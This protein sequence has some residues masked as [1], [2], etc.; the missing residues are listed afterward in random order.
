MTDGTHDPNLDA[1]R[2]VAELRHHQEELHQQNE[3]LLHARASAERALAE[4][5]D[6][7]DFAPVGYATVDADG[8]VVAANLSLAALFGLGRE[9]IVGR[10]IASWIAPTDRTRLLD[11]LGALKET[12]PPSTLEAGLFNASGDYR[13]VALTAARVAGTTT[14]RIAFSDQTRRHEAERAFQ[15]SQKMEAIG[16][17]AS[18]VAHDLNN[19]FTVVMIHG[20]FCLQELP[21]GSPARADI[22]AMMT[23]IER[24]GA[25]TTRLLSFA[26]PQVMERRRLDASTAV[27]DFAR[28][29]RATTPARVVIACDAPPH[30]G[31]IQFDPAQLEQLL[32]NLANN[33]VD[34]MPD[35][36]TLTLAVQPATLDDAAVAGE[37]TSPGEFIRVRVEDTGVGMR[38][39]VLAHA[40]EPFF[41]TK[42][43]GKGIGLGLATVYAIVHG[44]GGVVRIRSVEGRGTTVDIYLPRSERRPTPTS[45]PTA[46]ATTGGR[47]TILIVEDEPLIRRLT[48]RVLS[49]QGY[50]VHTAEDGVQ[51]LERMAVLGDAVD[52][53]LSDVLMPRMAGPEFVRRVR[54]QR[55]EMPVVFMTGYA[56]SEELQGLDV[57]ENSGVL[58]KP[59]PADALRAT[60]R[61]ALDRVR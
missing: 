32:V 58:R 45:I 31:F 15:Q 5:R 19:Q 56:T 30:S 35:G 23:A 37:N 2:L 52:I 10:P 33:A 28:R 53:I 24:A 43:A 57:P 22:A 26:R 17:L 3:A 48:E 29:L 41:S 27:G 36:G 60:I 59:F 39:D 13:T 50:T 8:T 25:M 16:R 61:A 1:Q 6:L 44:A 38:A 20:E 4:C 21:D 34:A 40:F 51:G 47:E 49:R 14:S 18:S 42:A 54:E 9:R 11:F 12:D 46:D 55:P 7:Y